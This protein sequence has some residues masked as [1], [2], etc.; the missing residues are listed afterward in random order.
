MMVQ[1]RLMV[2]FE[3]FEILSYKSVAEDGL[4]HQKWSKQTLYHVGVL[5][6]SNKHVC[7]Y[8]FKYY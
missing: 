2:G 6:S 5:F 8:I 4:Y 1:T 7:I 3:Y